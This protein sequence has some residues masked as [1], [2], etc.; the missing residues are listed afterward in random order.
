MPEAVDLFAEPESS[1]EEIYH[2]T[3]LALQ[4]H[5]LADL[6]IQ[7]IADESEL[8]KS[9]IYHHFDGKDDLLTSFV[10]EFMQEHVDALL[11]ELPEDDLLALF[12]RSLDLFILGEAP[13]GTTLDSLVGD[14]I[15]DVYLQLRAHA[16]TNP[17]YQRA[18]AD[19]DRVARERMIALT[20]LAK[21]EGLFREDVDPERVAATLFAF[22]ETSLLVQCTSDDTEWLRHVRAS[23]ED[24]VAGLVADGVEWPPASD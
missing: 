6:S 3:W 11:L 5:S 19:A 9:T 24:Y 16:A 21:Q 4:Q 8:G 20:E 2:A 15:N 18:M 14:K 13:D 23:A 22:I 17:A 1:E 7:R 12:E 10:G